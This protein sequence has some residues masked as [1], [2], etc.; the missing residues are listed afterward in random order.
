M[1]DGR[2]HPI[3]GIEGIPIADEIPGGDAGVAVA[4]M[5]LVGGEHGAHHLVVAGVG[6][7]RGDDPVAPAEHLRGAVPDVGHVPAAV[8][9]GI[10]PHIHPMPAPSFAVGRGVEE[11][12]DEPVVGIGGGVGKEGPQVVAR[13]RQSGEIERHAP[14]ERRPIGS[15]HRL[16]AGCSELGVE[17]AIDRMARAA[18]PHRGQ[19]CLLG[20][21][22]RPVVTPVVD[23]ALGGGE[24]RDRG[25]N[26]QEGDGAEPSNEKAPRAP[27]PESGGVLSRLEQRGH[28][29]RPG[30]SR[31]V[32]ATVTRRF[33]P[34]S[35]R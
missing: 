16:E 25:Q 15:S 29:E 12:V 10:A 6:I 18:R 26:C 32:Y 9:V 33:P 11:P 34:P 4:R 35:P 19:C 14:Q 8:P 21:H 17:E 13:R 3:I 5:E 28:G 1:L 31:R 2:S 30:R 27:L 22:E 24:I 23:G 7:E 20:S